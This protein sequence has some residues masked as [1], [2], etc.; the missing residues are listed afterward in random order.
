MGLQATFENAEQ[1]L[2]PGMFARVE[3]LLP[4]EQPVLVIPATAVLSAPY[5]DSVYVIESKPGKDSAK[6]NLVVR[7][8]FIRTGPGA[9]RFCQRGVGPQGRATASSAPGIFKLRNGMAVI[10]NNDLAP[11]TDRGAAARR[12]VDPQ[13]ARMKSFTDLFIRRPVLALV[14]NLVILIAGL[15]GDPL[16]HRPAIS[17]QRQRGGHRHHRLC[18]RQRGPGARLHHHAAGARHRRRRRH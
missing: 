13:D 17:A 10:E 6:P 3:V 5:G 11:K 7:Q 16:A 12:T 1:L 8:Q 2:R 4:E 15:P 18:R 9:R 14:V